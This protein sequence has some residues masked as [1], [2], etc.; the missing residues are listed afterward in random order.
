[1]KCNT[2][3]ADNSCISYN[4]QQNEILISCKYMEFGDIENSLQDQS[5]L[6]RESSNFN[7]KNWILNAGI[8][9]E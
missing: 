8:T 5:I 3:A 6:Q 1:M 7:E 2:I 4:S 9:V